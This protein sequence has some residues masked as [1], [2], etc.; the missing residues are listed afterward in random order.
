MRRRRGFQLQE[1][2]QRLLALVSRFGAVTAEQCIKWRQFS[3]KT[4][5]YRRLKALC[6]ERL[7]RHDNPYR[8]LPGYYRAT[9]PGTEIAQ[10]GLSPVRIDV[11][12]TARIRHTLAVVDLA[13]Y[14]LSQVPDYVDYP[15]WETEREIRSRRLG[16]RRDPNTGRMLP[17]EQAR[18]PD[19]ILRY[20]DSHAIAVELELTAK[21]SSQYE[22]IF[23]GY[24][25]FPVSLGA[26][27]LWWFFAS[28]EASRRAQR[29]LRDADPILRDMADNGSIRFLRWNS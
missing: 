19:G 5:A 7:L 16:A 15:E 11:A 13:W 26:D 27:E 24:A 25:N 22:E 12:N 8:Y 6:D 14:M 18:T 21:S 1:R 29:I 20:S 2:D 17:G 23:A 9:R 10:T 28:E 4:S 3:S